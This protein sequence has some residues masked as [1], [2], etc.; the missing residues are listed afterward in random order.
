MTIKKLDWQDVPLLIRLRNS[1]ICLEPRLGFTH[2]AK[3]LRHA[4][5]D[6]FTPGGSA[7]TLVSRSRQGIDGYGQI[8][9]RLDEPLASLLYLA[10]EEML[11]HPD[12]IE[13]LSAAAGE[14]GAFNLVA[15]ISESHPGFVAL[16]HADFHIFARQAIW[17]L[18]DQ[19]GPAPDSP[20]RW[21]RQHLKDRDAVHCLYVNLVPVLV[22]QVEKLPNRSTSGLVYWNHT[23]LLGSVLLDRG[24]GGS[25]AQLLIH[26]AAEQVPE[27]ILDFIH[28]AG[29]WPQPLYILVRSYQSWMGPVLEEVGFEYIGSQAVMVKRLAV[30]L[31]KPA[32]NQV[33]L[34]EP[35]RPE[36][37]ASMAE[38]K[39]NLPLTEG[40][41]K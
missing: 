20:S 16:R 24:P 38:F 12:M 37:T 6:M 40:S 27:L 33:P 10:P 25:L 17:Q 22:Q 5:E 14:R 9:H 32:V 34:M 13:A 8:L 15:S 30:G 1:G 28:H 4:F 26:P 18:V 19:P 7:V 35:V 41:K 23:D 21:R 36:V 3:P 11:E 29:P 31:H 2:G 39:N